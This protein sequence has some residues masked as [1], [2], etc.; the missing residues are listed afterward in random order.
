MIEIK[1][2]STNYIKDLSLE[3]E[4]GV[5][6]IVSETKT[7][8]PDIIAGLACAD[9]GEVIID[10]I[11]V[12]KDTISAKKKISY[13]PEGASLYANMTVF[14]YLLFIGR[15]KKVNAERL[16]RQIDEVFELLGLFRHKNVLI[17]N[18]DACLE[19]KLGLAGAL[20]GNPSVIVLDGFF[21]NTC[22]SDTQSVIK[23]LGQIKTVIIFSGDIRE[24]GEICD[25]VVVLSDSEQSILNRD[26]IAAELALNKVE[27]AEEETETEEVDE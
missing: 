20:L 4:A 21:S 2:L 5:L 17:S 12:A 23:M 10:G 7:S 6:G 1:N 19:K 16:Y 22:D 13:L 27:E 26:E 25:T 18:L 14:E 15:A 8:L 24:I 3:L 11:D 9:S